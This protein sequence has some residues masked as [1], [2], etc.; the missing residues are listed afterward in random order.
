MQ[1]KLTING[2][3][4][5]QP[6]E[7]PQVNY[8]TKYTENSGRLTSGFA[9]AVPLFTVL[10]LQYTWSKLTG[11]ELAA[12]LQEIIGKTFTLHYYN[13]YKG[14]WDDSVFYVGKGT[15]NQWTLYDGGEQ[16]GLSFN[17]ECVDP[18]QVFSLAG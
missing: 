3:A 13:N 15:L 4:V 14:A 9:I 16:F 11:A 5:R 2:K 8:E 12:I 1:H 6:D 17:A 18:S 10:Q 7:S